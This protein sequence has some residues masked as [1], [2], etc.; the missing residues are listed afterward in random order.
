M[1]VARHFGCQTFKLIKTRVLRTMTCA[2]DTVHETLAFVVEERVF[3]GKKNN[4][5]KH[6]AMRYT[7][8]DVEDVTRPE[9]LTALNCC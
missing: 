9:N 5:N 7:C 2:N 1:T 4:C 3:F 8:K 6:K